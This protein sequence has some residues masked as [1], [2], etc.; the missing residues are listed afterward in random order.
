MVWHNLAHSESPISIRQWGTTPYYTHTHIQQQLI[1]YYV[2]PNLNKP[3][4]VLLNTFLA[5]PFTREKRQPH[6]VIIRASTVLYRVN[7]TR[8]IRFRGCFKNIVQLLSP[9]PPGALSVDLYT[10]ILIISSVQYPHPALFYCE[11]YQHIS[12]MSIYVCLQVIQFIGCA[13]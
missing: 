13:L 10:L 1:L 4:V 9:S 12:H 2:L 6:E 5:F 7:K 3:F 11:A 8:Q